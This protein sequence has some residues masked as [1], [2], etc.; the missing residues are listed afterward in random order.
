MTP[1]ARQA[2]VNAIADNYVR[3]PGTPLRA[4]RRDR[5][6]AA[7]LHD[8]GIPLRAVWA[9]FVMAAA[10]WAIR[11]PSQRR[12]EP[13]RTLYYFL[14]ALDEVLATAP[15][16]DY[17]HYLATKLGPLVREKEALLAELRG[18]QE[19]ALPDGR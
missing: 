16:A 6:L 11:G 2:Y 19:P 18:G 7:A 15:E 5:R 4:S 10:R 17:V 12:L 1:S 9:A 8:R 14:P 3:L 13:I